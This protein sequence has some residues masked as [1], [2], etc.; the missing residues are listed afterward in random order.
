MPRRP[1][2]RCD[3]GTTR[4][5]REDAGRIHPRGEEDPC[6]IIGTPY[7][8]RGLVRI[9]RK[10]SKS[11]VRHQERYARRPRHPEGYPGPVVRPTPE[12]LPWPGSE[13]L[14]DGAAQAL[15]AGGGA[16]RGRLAQGTPAERV[17]RAPPASGGPAAGAVPLPRCP[18]ARPRGGSSPGRSR[19]RRLP[20]PAGVGCGED[21]DA[22]ER[23]GQDP[24]VRVER[25]I[26]GGDAGRG[27]GEAL[28]HHAERRLQVLGG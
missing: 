6:P 28:P 1:G 8:K 2:A 22:H 13:D 15:R 5:Q 3:V 16:G 26:V 25:G 19:G 9:G 4:P 7:A 12:T 21:P 18:V 20:C 11:T 17:R 14:R 24:P 10:A 27:D 23:R